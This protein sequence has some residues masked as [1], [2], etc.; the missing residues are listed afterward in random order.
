ME[1]DEVEEA[2]RQRLLSYVTPH[3]TCEDLFAR[4]AKTRIDL[5]TSLPFLQGSPDHQHEHQ[6]Q[7]RGDGRL[8][9]RAGQVM[10]IC[11]TN[12]T[13]KTE[14]LLQAAATCVLPKSCGGCAS[15]AIFM[16]MRSGMDPLRLV[17]IL[18]SRIRRCQSSSSSGS[19]LLEESLRRFEL[20]RCYNNV[21]LVCALKALEQREREEEAAAPSS[22]ERPRRRLVLVDDISAFY[23]I[24]KSFD[25]G[26][27]SAPRRRPADRPYGLQGV[28][29][30]IASNLRRSAEALG[31]AVLATRNL[32]IPPGGDPTKLGAPL[33][34]AWQDL[35]SQRVVLRRPNPYA[36]ALVASWDLPKKPGTS[37]R[38]AVRDDSLEAL[39]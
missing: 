2:V 30:A 17:Q 28:Y 36:N 14:C 29:E 19:Q 26:P 33:P 39:A 35:V 38:F 16:E 9:V 4:L 12:D 1:S 21:D 37:F 22:Q 34:K 25:G 3:E 32:Q 18:D 27:G 8:R 10:E 7:R 6:E 24:D 11:G 13:C 5:R 15:N 23:W 20:V 31:A